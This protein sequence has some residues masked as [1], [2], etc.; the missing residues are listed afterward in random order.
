MKKKR[1]VLMIGLLTMLLI[2]A[3]CSKEAECDGCG[4]YTKV[5]TYTTSRGSTKEYCDTCMNF[6]KLMG[7]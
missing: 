6:A 1:M 3:G 7:E 4:Q 2:F 5:S